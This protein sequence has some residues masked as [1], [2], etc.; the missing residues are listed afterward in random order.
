MD[1]QVYKASAKLLLLLATIH[2]IYFRV[3]GTH[4]GASTADGGSRCPTQT[5]LGQ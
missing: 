1:P 4:F 3:F 2:V 5:A